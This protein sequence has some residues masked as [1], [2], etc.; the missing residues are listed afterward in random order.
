MTRSIIFLAVL[1]T[2]IPTTAWAQVGGSTRADSRVEQLL[3]AADIPFKID[4]DGDFRIEQ[5]AGEDR[6][7]LLWVLSRTS[8]LGSL[9]IRDIW[10]VAYRSKEP[11]SAEIA[12]R[13]LVAN[14][15]VKLGAWQVQEIGGEYLAIFQA[16][17]A[18]ET[19]QES[20]TMAMAAVMLTADAM[21]K[22]LTGTDDF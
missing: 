2:V 6:T 16:Q 21:E 22:E 5:V 3:T 18:A 10:S 7:Q 15:D 17:I 20:L 8:Q 9:E 4:E 14:S 1:T 12:N 13:L 19:D 11:L